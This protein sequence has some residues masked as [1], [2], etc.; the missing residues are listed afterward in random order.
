VNNLTFGLLLISSTLPNAALSP[1]CSILSLCPSQDTP[2]NIK[3]FDLYAPRQNRHRSIL[4][5]H[6]PISA[7][8]PHFLQST[9]SPHSVALGST[10]DILVTA[11]A[12]AG[13]RRHPGHLCSEPPWITD[14][15]SRHRYAFTTRQMSFRRQAVT[16]PALGITTRRSQEVQSSE[17]V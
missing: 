11:T 16:K 17:D 8:F 4:T 3:A 12:L 14:R 1:T 15:R 9:Y 7:S 10:Y 2:S 6:P 13:S 5:V